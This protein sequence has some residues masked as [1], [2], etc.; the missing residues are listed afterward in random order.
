MRNVIE[1]LL[2]Y[3]SVIFPIALVGT[4]GGILWLFTLVPTAQERA[5]YEKEEKER[6][7]RN[8][9]YTPIE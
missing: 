3:E 4:I 2:K 7:R 9:Q 8:R 1:F 5:E 6:K